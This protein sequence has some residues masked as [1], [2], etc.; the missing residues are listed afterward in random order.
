MCRNDDN[1]PSMSV[2]SLKRASLEDSETGCA[3]ELPSS[4]KARELQITQG[5]E[6]APAFNITCKA[7]KST[8]TFSLKDDVFE[9]SQPTI[10][11][12]KYMHMSREDQHTILL[13]ISDALR[14]FASYEQE[15]DEGLC[16]FDQ[17]EN[18]IMELGLE[19]IVEQQSSDRIQRVKSAICVI[20]QHQRQS[21]LRHPSKKQQA[22]TMSESWLQKHYRPFSQLSAKLAR[23][24]G[25]LDQEMAP[26]LFPRQIVMSR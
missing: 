1:C 26:S 18:D 4:K 13:E 15:Q 19:R 24:R 3:E 2:P 23:S 11:E 10:E 14:R 16:A 6:E 7:R 9:I 8:V 21:Q 22:Y 12:K 20:L 25:L 5:V 17:Y